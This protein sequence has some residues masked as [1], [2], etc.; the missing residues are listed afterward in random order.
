[1]AEGAVASRF[2]DGMTPFLLDNLMLGSSKGKDGFVCIL[3]N[4]DGN[5]IE[6][7]DGYGRRAIHYAASGDCVKVIEILLEHGAAIDA[8]DRNGATALYYAAENQSE[9][10][11]RLLIDHGAN[12]S[13]MILPG[14][15]QLI[16][17]AS[18]SRLTEV[19]ESSE[20]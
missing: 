19:K 18:T 9:K 4:H 11:V 3:P 2:E 15:L 20:C 17:R 8:R 6:A 12:L 16:M 10:V 5:V 13:F 1:M 7:Q 14:R